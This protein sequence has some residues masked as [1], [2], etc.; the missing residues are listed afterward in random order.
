MIPGYF[1]DKVG[2]FNS[3]ILITALSGIITL[4][5]WIPGSSNTAAIIVYAVLFG[6]TSGG[7][8]S[9]APVCVAQLSDIREI[10]ARTG[11]VFLVQGIGALTGS[12][13][14]GAIVQAQGGSFTGLQIYCGVA[15]LVATCMYIGARF[16]QVGTKL[17]V[18]V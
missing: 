14:G 3:M 15:M 5:L 1:A 16:M 6:F 17:A 12:P 11:V 10:G 7:F 4:A 8:I 18:K 2:R 13:I 9:L